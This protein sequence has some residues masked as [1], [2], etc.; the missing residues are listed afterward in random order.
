MEEVVV[1]VARFLGELLVQ[2]L[3]SLPF[4]VLDAKHRSPG[5]TWSELAGVGWFVAGCA[6]G[7]LS[8]V[9]LP[10]RVIASPTLRVAALVVAPLASARAARSLA[11]SGGADGD[12]D[13][14]VVSRRRYWHAFW[15]TFGLVAVRFVGVTWV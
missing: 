3:I 7:G 1:V 15:F 2:V 11:W 10:H 13:P 4:D 8:L 6:A 12:G 9:A 14:A 5:A